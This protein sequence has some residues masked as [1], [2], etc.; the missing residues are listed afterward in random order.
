VRI[1]AGYCL[2]VVS[3]D[4]AGVLFGSII[5]LLMDLEFTGK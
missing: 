3:D 2:Y 5:N 1:I 4:T